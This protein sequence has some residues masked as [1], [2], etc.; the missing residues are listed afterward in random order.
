MLRATGMDDEALARPMVAVIS[1]FTDVM[2]CTMH[3]RDLAEH[4]ATGVREAGGTP[5]QFGTIA[6]S[7]GIAMG[8]PGMRASLISREVI[9]D[10]IELAVT[11]HSLDGVVLVVGCDKTL[12]AAAMALL[13]LDVPGV[14]LY[15][16]SI[17]AGHHN[18]RDLTVQDM[19]EAVGACA[20]GDM[21][22][23]EVQEL[24]RAAC[25][26]AGACGGQFTANTMAMVLTIL[27]LSPMGAND[28]PATD[29]QKADVARACGRTAMAAVRADRRPRSFVCEAALQEAATA[30]LASGGSTNAVLHLLAIA[31]EAEVPFA[32]EQFDAE[33]QRAAVLL[34]LKP[35][36]AFTAVDFVAAGGTPTFARKLQELGLLSDRPTISGATMFAELQRTNDIEGQRVIRATDDPVR[37]TPG[38]AILHGNLAPEGCVVK[39]G[40]EHHAGTFTG[41]A[42]VFESEEQ[43]FDAVQNSVIADGSVIVIRNEGPRGGP[44]MREMLAVTGALIGK[45]LGDRVALITDGR[46]S[47]ATHGLMV[48]H[49]APEAACGGAIGKLRNGDQITIDVPGRRLQVAS[50]VL[51]RAA[52]APAPPRPKGVF[53]R[54]AALVNSA[55]RG[56]TTIPGA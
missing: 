10:S 9:A 37:S 51:Q 33:R 50:E 43:A 23:E 7:D 26:S 11:G 6:V 29:P 34:D 2:P 12:P 8:T 48:G 38:L 47:G 20:A 16:G 52:N 40:K 36:G 41:P 56:A 17:A 31:A 1:T 18:G 45:G 21:Q 53:A 49:V 15:G 30:V 3:L 19:F 22:P 25:P 28:V 4:A 5:V 46:F 39:L 14:I 44:G 35:S 13:R 42:R 27:G 32:I 55:A 24:E 54:Y